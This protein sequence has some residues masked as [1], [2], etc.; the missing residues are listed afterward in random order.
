[1]NSFDEYLRSRR[2]QLGLTLRKITAEL[3]IDISIL[4]KIER[5]ERVATNEMLPALAKTF[6][7]QEMEIGN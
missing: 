7:V 6:E 4:S 5:N 1:M 2:E 3:D